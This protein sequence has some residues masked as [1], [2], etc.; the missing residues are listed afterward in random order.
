MGSE[1]CIRDRKFTA[2]K[3]TEK[4]I[5]QWK[6]QRYMKNYLGTVKAVDES[7]GRILDYLDE[8]KLAENTVVIYSSDQG[9]YLGEH[10]WYD[11]RWMFEESLKMP[12][13]IRWPGV[14]AEGSKP[15]E[16]IQ[17]IDYAPTFLEMAGLKAPAEVQ[18]QSLLPIL[19]DEADRKWRD[20][21]YYGYY[22]LGE[23]N[24][25]QHF[26]IRTQTQKLMYF[27]ETKEWNL[28][29]LSSDPNEMKNVYDDSNYA[30][31]RK[32]LTA[33]FN[34]VRGELKAPAFTE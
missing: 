29:D 16:M 34:R 11:K 2:G 32:K 28:F 14:V 27:P 19:K 30:E 23:H 12:F 26:G 17:N 8:N 4:E 3:L 6:Y 9:F 21:I 10:G 7:V 25:P 20:S 1:M 31:A 5:T 15:E 18:G 33:E 24:V 22:E 13:V